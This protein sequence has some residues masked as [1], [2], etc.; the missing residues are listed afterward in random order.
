M[1]LLPQQRRCLAFHGRRGWTA[2]PAD[3]EPIP[4]P[5]FGY[6]GVIDERLDLPLIASL[7]EARP[8]GTWSSSDRST[9]IEEGLL[10]RAA[11]I[12]YLGAKPYEALPAYIG[13]D[14]MSP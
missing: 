2:Q 1:S 6:C 3:Q 13:R 9:K 8:A 5:R 10:P 7:A 4:R 14:G 12:H 11:N